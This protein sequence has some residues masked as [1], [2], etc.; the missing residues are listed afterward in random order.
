MY[1]IVV[2]IRKDFATSRLRV[3][4][5]LRATSQK[6]YKEDLV[7]QFASGPIPKNCVHSAEGKEAQSLQSV[8]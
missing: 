1:W 7:C 8:R 3:N 5:L 2:P 6:H 4:L